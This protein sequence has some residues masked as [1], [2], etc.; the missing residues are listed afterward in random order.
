MISYKLA[1]VGINCENEQEAMQTAA[2][3]TNMFGWETKTGTS[4]VFARRE[5]ECMKKPGLGRLGHIAISTPN[6]ALAM[7]DLQQRG[8]D[9][10]SETLKKNEREEIVAVYLAEEVGGFAIHLLKEK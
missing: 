7:A 6:V 5:I 1:H 8:F 10:M 9:F 4:S 2:T 3:F